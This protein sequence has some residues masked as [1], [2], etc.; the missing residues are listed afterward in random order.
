MFIREGIGKVSVRTLVSV[1]IWAMIGAVMVRVRVNGYCVDWG[2]CE[3]VLKFGTVA[4]CSFE[5]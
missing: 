4:K 1:L 2:R 5:R 3:S